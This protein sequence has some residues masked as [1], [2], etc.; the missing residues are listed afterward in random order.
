MIVNGNYVKDYYSNNEE[1]IFLFSLPFKRKDP[2]GA[3]LYKLS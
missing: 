3:R 2:N 1:Y